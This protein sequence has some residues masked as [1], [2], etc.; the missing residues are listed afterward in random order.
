MAP[1]ALQ[2]RL[3]LKINRL[4]NGILVCD[5][6]LFARKSFQWASVNAQNAYPQGKG[7]HLRKYHFGYLLGVCANS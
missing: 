6:R 5:K 3:G 4:N 7:I 2:I 1:D